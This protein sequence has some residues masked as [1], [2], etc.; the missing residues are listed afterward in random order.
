MFFPHHASHVH[1]ISH[2]ANEFVIFTNTKICTSLDTV[3]RSVGGGA[4]SNPIK[5]NL[6]NF[7]ILKLLEHTLLLQNCLL[8]I[9]KTNSSEH[10]DGYQQDIWQHTLHTSLRSTVAS[11]PLSPCVEF[12]VWLINRKSA[13]PHLLLAPDIFIGEFVSRTYI[14]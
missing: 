8:L 2:I 7:I 4:L 1:D 10:V 6:S 3:Q 13:R 12:N 9:N 5:K 11:I 14:V